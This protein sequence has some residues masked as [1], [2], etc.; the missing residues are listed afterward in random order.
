MIVATAS[1][2]TSRIRAIESDMAEDPVWFNPPV[3]VRTKNVGHPRNVNNARAASEELL[4]WERRPDM[5]QGRRGL[6]GRA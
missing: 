1:W 3:K 6:Y 2:N 5:A 4:Q